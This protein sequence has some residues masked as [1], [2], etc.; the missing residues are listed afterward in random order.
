MTYELVYTS[1]ARRDL[2][3]AADYI[4]RQAP[5][6]A[7]RWFNGF[8]RTLD[9]LRTD[10]VSYSTAPESERCSVRVQQIFYRTK[11]RQA[12]RAL[13]TIRGSTVY[14]LAIRRPGQDLLTEEELEQAVTDLD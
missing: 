1:R 4:A 9:R 5:E 10:A 6:T 2:N 14:I 13:F 12:N 8:G 7:Q 11:S 3:S